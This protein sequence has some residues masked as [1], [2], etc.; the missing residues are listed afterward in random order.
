MHIKIAFGELRLGYQNYIKEYTVTE[1][2]W[3]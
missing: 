3:A 1:Y 2:G